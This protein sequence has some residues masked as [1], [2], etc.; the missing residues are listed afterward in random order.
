M[1]ICICKAVTESQIDE[2]Y[3]NGATSI[4]DLVKILGVGTECHK[5]LCGLK[6]RLKSKR[7]T[8]R[9]VR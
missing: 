4:R 3:G 8:S 1:Y 6:D 9:G 7:S 5:C 2:A